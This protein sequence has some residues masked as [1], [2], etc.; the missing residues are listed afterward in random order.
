[1]EASD[2]VENIRLRLGA[3]ACDTVRRRHDPMMLMIDRRSATLG[4]SLGP[5]RR[6]RPRAPFLERAGAFGQAK[7]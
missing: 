4:R 5:A 3:R 6:S 2:V 7:L 1:V